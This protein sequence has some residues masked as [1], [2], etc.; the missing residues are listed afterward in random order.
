MRQHGPDSIQRIEYG[1]S[2]EPIQPSEDG[3]GEVHC[4]HQQAWCGSQ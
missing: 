4:A 2:R 3:N 1:D